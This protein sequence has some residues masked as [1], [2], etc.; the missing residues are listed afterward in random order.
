MKLLRYFTILAFLG[1]LQISAFAQDSAKSFHIRKGYDTLKFYSVGLTAQA[2]TGNAAIYKVN[3]KVVNKATY[4][5]YKSNWDNIEKCRPC[6]LKTYNVHDSLIR[7]GLQYEDCAVGD[8]IEYYPDGKIKVKGHYKEN[9]TG[10]W[11]SLYD[12]GYCSRKDGKWTYY[13]ENGTVIK[14]ENYI[15]D[16]LVK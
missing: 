2:Q 12:R 10:N 13:N 3:N 14:V 16:K 8:W 15:D 5:K 11:D 1:F 7:E 6:Y 4:D 9:P